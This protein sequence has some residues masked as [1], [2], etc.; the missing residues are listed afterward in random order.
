MLETKQEPRKIL[1]ASSAF[2]PEKS[3]RSFRATELAREFARQGHEVTVLTLPY[4]I[5]TES[6]CRAHGINLKYVAKPRL[7]GIK[8]RET[9]LMALAS[10][11]LN[12]LL[13][14]IL[15]YPKIE[16]MFSYRNALEKEH[17]FDMLISFAVPYPVHW[18]VALARTHSRQISQ[19][20][21]ADCGDP[22]VGNESDSFKKLFYFRFIENWMF[23]KT[24]FISIPV[25]ASR[26]AYNPEFNSKIR[27]I[28]QGVDMAELTQLKQEYIRNDVPTF[29]YAGSFILG[30]RDPKQLLDFL[31]SLDKDF[32]FVIYTTM[33]SMIA[34]YVKQSKGRIKVLDYIPRKQLIAE[35]AKSDFLINI[36]NETPTQTPSKL[37]DY[38]LAG[39]PVLSVASQVT[40]QSLIKEF[41]NGDYSGAMRFQDFEDYKIE[42]VAKAFLNL[43]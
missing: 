17:G 31:N 2:L 4:G 9:G 15:E 19:T 6:F 30:K 38:Y 5:E 26:P 40:N 24:N 41:L 11:I 16:L 29:A 22:Y 18:G 23:R 39:R 3:P 14:M 8:I 10:R 20:W 37:I 42:N 33:G 32:L 34:D 27:C 25:E 21:V 43:K 12:R 13:L 28:P 1:L 36:E 7:H 35:L